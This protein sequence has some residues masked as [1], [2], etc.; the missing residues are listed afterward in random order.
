MNKKNDDEN[1]EMDRDTSA[2]K[3]KMKKRIPRTL[4]SNNNKSNE[5]NNIS[6]SPLIKENEIEEKEM[7][8]EEEEED[9][10][11]EDENKKEEEKKEENINNSSKNN[12]IE[13]NKNL[14]SSKNE[15]IKEEP[16]NKELKINVNL[17]N[18]ENS[19]N[20]RSTSCQVNL[21]NNKESEKII[22]ELKL[23]I[24]TLENEKEM[25]ISQLKENQ[26]KYEEKFAKQNKDINSLSLLN[27][28]LKKNL[29]K[30]NAQVTKL[31]NQVVANNSIPVTANNSK[32]VTKAEKN[33]G[34]NNEEKE[35][36]EEII[37]L[38]EKLKL[39]ESQI[40]ES[41]KTIE[42]LKKQ[43]KKIKED[44]DS[45]ALDGKNINENNKL[46][47]ELRE[48]NNELRELIKKKNNEL[49]EL[50]R[51]YKNLISY[52]SGDEHLE[53]NKNLVNELKTLKKQNDENKAKITQL[54][55]IVEKHQKKEMENKK[56]ANL[57]N[58]ILSQTKQNQEKIA[59][60]QIKKGIK[61]EFIEFN[62]KK[63]PMN[64]NFS[65]LFN[66]LE[67]KTLFSLFPD[68]GDFMRFNQKLDIIENNFNSSS[69]RFQTNINELKETID[70][71]EELIAY[72][73]E[74]I[75]ENEM[76]IKIL[77]NQIHLE[78]NKNEK[79]VNNQQQDSNDKN[80]IN[81]TRAKS[82]KK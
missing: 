55:Q 39:K 42:F 77:L 23:K 67:K 38:K 21:T 45:L 78:R 28:K 79:R 70:D 54:K 75:R 15:E 61:Y 3:D 11:N 80:I 20:I 52:K 10:I 46:V 35:P 19:K 69:K 17:K 1:L 81:D 31:L 37:A 50:E 34:K 5:I 64:K 4:N 72:L 82:P 49:R 68:E 25:L 24:N 57:N 53:Q 36:N 8:E 65:L 26:K 43:N 71:K 29:E 41:F 33:R 13:N 14:V 59:K 27:N 48:K 62:N 12:S 30:V 76:K 18:D 51:E 56:N 2:P 60:L 66:D 9:D 7:E 58:S 63:Y 74:K 73:R 32:M 47:E 22:Q 40:K 6:N 44:Y 16:N